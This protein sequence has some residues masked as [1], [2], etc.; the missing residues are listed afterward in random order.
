MK[1]ISIEKTLVELHYVITDEED[2]ISYTRYSPDRWTRLEIMSDEH[3]YFPQE[4][5]DEF[6]KYMRSLNLD[7]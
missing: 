2:Y 4:I 3:V 6:Q 5:E 1:I 7:K